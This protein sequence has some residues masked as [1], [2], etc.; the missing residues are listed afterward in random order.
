M[1][2]ALV[3]LVFKFF[4]WIAYYCNQVIRLSQCSKEIND[5]EVSDMKFDYP[6]SK[7]TL[8]SLTTSCI[9]Y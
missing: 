1:L 8:H 4:V 6:C 5:I 9:K 2:S 7:D 3:F